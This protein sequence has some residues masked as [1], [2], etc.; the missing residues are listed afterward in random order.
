MLT[1]W[2]RSIGL[3][4]HI[5]EKLREV[6]AD[7]SSA[8]ST[9]SGH[10]ND[11]AVDTTWQMG[12]SAAATLAAE[13]IDARVYNVAFDGR[14]KDAIKSNLAVGDFLDYPRIKSQVSI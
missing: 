11:G 7:V 5:K 1:K 12:W 6:F 13:L 10:P 4:V 9:F 2:L 8:H 14:Y 3:P